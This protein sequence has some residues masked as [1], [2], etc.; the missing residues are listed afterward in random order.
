MRRLALPSAEVVVIG[1][2]VWD[3]TAAQQAGCLS[4]GL[5]SGGSSGEDL[6]NAGAIMVLRDPAELA[7]RLGC[8][9]DHNAVHRIGRNEGRRD[10]AR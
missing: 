9:M 1:D 3:V 7:Q 4:V 6:R 10:E 8:T 5:L 2:S